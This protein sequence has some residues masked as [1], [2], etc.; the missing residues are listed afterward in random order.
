MYRKEVSMTKQQI[1]FMIGTAE[2][3]ETMLIQFSEGGMGGQTINETLS[4]VRN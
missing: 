1:E 3:T 4:Q 2:N